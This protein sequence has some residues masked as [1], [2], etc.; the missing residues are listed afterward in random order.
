ME[1]VCNGGTKAP[2]YED[3]RRLINTSF[4]LHKFHNLVGAT[5]GRP[6]VKNLDVKKS[7]DGDSLESAP[8]ISHRKHAVYIA[9]YRC[10]SVGED[11]PLPS[12]QKP[13]RLHGEP[14]KLTVMP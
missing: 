5:I 6:P 1:T 3:V 7:G 12:K 2:P 11:S 4:A 8:T 14:L 9:K 13:R 10:F